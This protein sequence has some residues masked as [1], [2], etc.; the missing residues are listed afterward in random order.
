MGRLRLAAKQQAFGCSISC[1]TM[2]HRSMSNGGVLL[3]TRAKRVRVRARFSRRAQ[4]SSYPS[5]ARAHRA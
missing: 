5:A 1:R 4:Q 3:L 2:L